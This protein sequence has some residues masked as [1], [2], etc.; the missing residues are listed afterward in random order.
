MLCISRWQH[1]VWWWGVAFFTLGDLRLS[2]GLPSNFSSVTVCA[3]VPGGFDAQQKMQPVS[4]ASGKSCVSLHSGFPQESAWW[5]EDELPRWNSTTST[6]QKH[7]LR[8]IAV[9]SLPQFNL[10]DKD[11]C[12]SRHNCSLQ[13]HCLCD[14][15]S[16]L[17]QVFKRA[18]LALV[19]LTG[20]FLK[21]QNSDLWT[22][23][24][25]RNSASLR[26]AGSLF[27]CAANIHSCKKGPQVLLFSEGLF[28]GFWKEKCDLS[29]PELLVGIEFLLP[30]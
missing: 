27:L 9:V 18:Q 5:H 3:G 2:Q 11:V 23:K 16:T 7:H 1:L 21:T 24:S 6:W 13:M 25:C 30:W 14:R 19:M 20:S 26:S 17:G 15:L 29:I 8:Y 4:R 10:C 22:E 28:I 12:C